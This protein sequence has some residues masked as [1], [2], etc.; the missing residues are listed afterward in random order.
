[1][2]LACLIFLNSDRGQLSILGH[3]ALTR[4]QTNFCYMLKT[5]IHC[6]I[7]KLDQCK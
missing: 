4:V 6:S 5:N 1:M 2:L 7:E 3:I